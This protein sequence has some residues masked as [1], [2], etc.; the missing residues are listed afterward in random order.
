MFLKYNLIKRILRFFLF[1]TISILFSTCIESRELRAY[2]RDLKKCHA[3]LLSESELGKKYY[4]LYEPCMNKQHI[5]DTSNLLD[6]IYYNRRYNQF[7]KSEEVAGI[8]FFLLNKKQLVFKLSDYMANKDYVDTFLQNK[9]RWTGYAV[10]N[11]NMIKTE[12]LY[13]Y[14]WELTHQY[15]IY[16]LSDGKIERVTQYRNDNEGRIDG[17]SVIFSID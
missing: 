7:T 5:S 2:G 1:A 17:I 4:N 12:I 3:G 10:I 14:S 13:N 9:S 16:R 6:T 8:I 15:S 11:N